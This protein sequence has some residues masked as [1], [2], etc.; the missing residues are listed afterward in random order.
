MGNYFAIKTYR[1]VFIAWNQIKDK[2]NQK[3]VNM[4][5]IRAELRRRP[6]LA[7][8]LRA[9]KNFTMLK[10]F[11]KLLVGAKQSRNE[12]VKEEDA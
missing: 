9:L 8:P 11:N 6:E 1:K 7:K 12:E 4:Y 5:R 2:N 10:A 3:R